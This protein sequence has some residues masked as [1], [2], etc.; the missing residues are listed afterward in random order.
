M[1]RS[2]VEVLC[3][4]FY[5]PLDRLVR[6]GPSQRFYQQEHLITELDDQG[7]RS[8][9]RHGAQPL[10]QQNAAG[11]TRLLATDHAHSPLLALSET[12]LQ[13][14]S[15][16]SYGYAPAESGLSRLLGFNGECPERVTG[17]YLL[18][19]G[20]RAFNPVLMRFNS[21]DELSPFEEGGINS[22]AYCMGDPINAYDPTGYSRTG[23]IRPWNYPP[24]TKPR[25][26]EDL[27]ALHRSS[28]GIN[29]TSRTSRSPVRVATPTDTLTFYRK[30]PS[31]T[32]RQQTPNPGPSVEKSSRSG[33]WYHNNKNTE[34]K[35]K[36]LPENQQNQYRNRTE[37][38]EQTELRTWYETEMARLKKDGMP[39]KSK[40]SNDYHR[41]KA[42]LKR[43]EQQINI[44]GY[45]A[46][47]KDQI[48]K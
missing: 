27:K 7:Q 31:P 45:T 28:T 2:S 34:Q 19:Q 13:Q 44:A 37:K 48:R 12:L 6:A 23:I 21:P 40:N 38:P 25:S 47:L 29:R 20:T 3:R 5:D 24:R 8:I 35:F 30:S 36:N 33:K 39:W 15:Y 11:E 10:A 14:I 42:S 16:T 43:L 26:L 17:H 9:L 4:Y 22:Y 18:G 41:H 46:Y 32:P 1:S